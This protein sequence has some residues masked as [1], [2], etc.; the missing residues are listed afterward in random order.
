SAVALPNGV[1]LKWDPTPLAGLYSVQGFQ[2]PELSRVLDN[3]TDHT[4]GTYWLPPGVDYEFHILAAGP[5]TFTTDADV[6][7]TRPGSGA[8]LLVVGGSPRAGATALR[9]RLEKLGLAVTIRTSA[10]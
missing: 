3:W 2:L 10:Q 1:R 4:D 5:R 7:Q 6:I 8:A 9:A